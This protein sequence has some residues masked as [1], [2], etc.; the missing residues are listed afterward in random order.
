MNV[1]RRCRDN[2]PNLC[3]CDHVERRGRLK[4]KLGVECSD[5]SAG[6]SGAQPLVC[7]V[8]EAKNL[9]PMDP[10]GSSDPYVKVKLFPD[11]KSSIKQKTRVVRSSLDPVWDQTLTLELSP[12]DKDRR[13]LVEVWD[14][15]RTSR[16]DFMGCMSFGVSELMKQP[17]EGWFKLL[18]QEEGQFYNVPVPPEDV[19]LVGYLKT[20]IPAEERTESIDE[21][22][23]DSVNISED[24]LRSEDFHFLKLIGKG[25]FGK[26]LLAEIK[27]HPGTYYAVKVL[28]KDVLIQ[29][30]D[31]EAAVTEKRVLALKNKPPFLVAL[32]SCFQGSDHLFFVMEYVSGG[33]LMYQIQKHGRFKEP[34]A[35]FYSAE[36]AIGL[37][38]LHK[39]GIAYRD[40]KLDNVL[41]DAEGHV[42]IGK[43]DAA[44]LK[45]V[46]KLDRPLQRT[47]ACVRRGWSTGNRLEPSA[48]HRI[49]SLLRSFCTSRTDWPSIGKRSFP[50]ACLI[51]SA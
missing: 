39:R 24:V 18:A 14:W 34:V 7:K 3:G 44:S 1:H 5:Q 51:T 49:T 21:P 45:H 36:I 17:V 16:N 19:D 35:V 41:I 31:T 38:F 12:E 10:S 22:F 23:S 30:D 27:K 28:K 11:N 4:L 2:V 29:D 25:S 15:D 33:D 37:F 40:L 48:E 42:K 8:L 13:L 9:I 47:S 26:V 6:S 43:S 46:V 20:L 32:H 50:S